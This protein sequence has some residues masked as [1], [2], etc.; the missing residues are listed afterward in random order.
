MAFD[1]A[2]FINEYFIY[3]MR[4]PG[5]YAPYN[6][7][8]TAAFAIVAMVAVYCIYWA[9]TK[10]LKLKIDGEFFF[11]AVPFVLFGAFLRVIQ[12][13]S[14]LPREVVVAGVSLFPFITPGIYFLVFFALAAGFV[15]SWIVD[16]K[17]VVRNT[18]RIGWLFALASFFVLVSRMSFPNAIIG[19]GIIALATVCALAFRF[20]DRKF[21]KKKTENIELATVFGQC[22]DGAATFL[23]VGFAGYGEQHVVGN[24]VMANLGGPVAFFL[25]KVAFAF[26]VIHVARREFSKKPEDAQA[27]A[28]LLLLIAIFGA[29]P[30]TRDLSRIVLGV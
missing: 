4:Y 19:V 24:A 2:A 14:L 7:Y 22:L 6:A 5:Q 9:I 18:K 23:G 21:F 11:A 10:K 3:P 12:D 16:R 26:V 29:G 13:A 17:S 30:G 27:R 28:F 8:N 1:V 20:A 25:L 15:A